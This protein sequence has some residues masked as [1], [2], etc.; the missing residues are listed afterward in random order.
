MNNDVE[1]KSVQGKN[2]ALAE[3]PAE[4]RGQRTMLAIFGIAFV[5]VILAYLFFFHF[6]DILSG[7]TTNRGELIQPAMRFSEH[8]HA[9][10]WS[11]IYIGDS[12]CNRD[13][14]ERLY[15]MRQV[16]VALGKDAQ[17]LRQLLLPVSTELDETF[18][19]LIS[20][21]HPELIIEWL[22]DDLSRMGLTS[23]GHWIYLMDPMGNL[24]LRFSPENSGQDML[25]DL[26]HLLKLSRVG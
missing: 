25:K 12:K 23:E 17:R 6:P 21:E 16:T 20:S 7:V 11:L 5:P 10:Y 2:S 26:K 15:L 4:R 1:T 18:D 9:G 24:M 13:C 8:H 19:T 3:Q 22:N 14:I